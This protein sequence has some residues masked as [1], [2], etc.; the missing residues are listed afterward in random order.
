MNR[1]LT[2]GYGYGNAGLRAFLPTLRGTRSSTVSD[3]TGAAERVDR[4]SLFA[5]PTPELLKSYR[6]KA[7][8]WDQYAE[9][10]R[11]LL[12]ERRPERE[13]ASGELD[14]ACLLC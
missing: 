2:I 4:V 9:A 14:H 3:A 8:S 5:R 12:R 1:I 10:Y 7:L 6:D 13:Y 11:N